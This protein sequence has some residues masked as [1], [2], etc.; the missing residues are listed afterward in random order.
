MRFIVQV[1]IEP[2]KA[3][4][5]SE[6]GRRFAHKAT[7]RLGVRTLY[8]RTNVANPRWWTCPCQTGAE[9]LVHTAR[10]DAA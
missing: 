6:C 4:C 5:C 2:D 3:S 7:R 8:G 9:V 1:R 10:R